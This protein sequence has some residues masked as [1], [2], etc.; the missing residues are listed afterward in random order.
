MSPSEQTALFMLVLTGAIWL[1]SFGFLGLIGH[2][3]A[4]I[5]AAVYKPKS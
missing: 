3:I 5:D 4:T 2:L 1:L